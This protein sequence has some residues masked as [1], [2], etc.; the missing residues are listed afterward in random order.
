LLQFFFR[1]F[2]EFII[3]DEDNFHFLNSNQKYIQVTLG[4]R[5]KQLLD[6]LQWRTQEKL[7]VSTD[8]PQRIGGWL[9][10]YEIV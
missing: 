2:I 8:T 7:G 1:R 6:R 5:W 10:M 4:T 3:N 9:V